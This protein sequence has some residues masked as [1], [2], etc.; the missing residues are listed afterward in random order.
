[1]NELSIYLDTHRAEIERSLRE[2]MRSFVTPADYSVVWKAYEKQ[3]IQEFIAVIKGFQMDIKMDFVEGEEGSDKNRLADLL[4]QSRDEQ[5]LI[6]I[7]ACRG[8]KK[9]ANDLGTIRQYPEKKAHYSACYDIWVKYDDS[10]KPIQ[11]QGI[12]FDRS[13][14]F[15]GRMSVDYGGGVS[16]RK[17]D[18]NMRPKAW[19]MFDDGTSYWNTLA[20]FEA[21]IARSRSFRANSIVCEHLED[22]TEADKKALLKKLNQHFGCA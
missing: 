12:Y 16:Y 13:Y 11:V 3:V 5:V 1:M 18:G 8:N 22:M 7:K 6:S 21:G 4:V 14:K 2:A 15:V 10:K 9:P 17:K 20:E 19:K